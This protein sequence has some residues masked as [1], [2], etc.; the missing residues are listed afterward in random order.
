L[1][2]GL[3]VFHIFFFL[4]VRAEPVDDVN[5]K[6]AD[7]DVYNVSADE[8]SALLPCKFLV[9]QGP[10]QLSKS[11]GVEYHLAPQNT[12]FQG[13]RL[14]SEHRACSADAKHIEDFAETRSK[15]I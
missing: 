6:S 14:A 12:G 9:S 11:G 10:H 3:G 15:T 2:T 4:W 7:E 13:E 1:E 8:D 5:I